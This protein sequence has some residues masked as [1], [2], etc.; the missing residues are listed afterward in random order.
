MI[1]DSWLYVIDSWPFVTKMSLFR[2]KK[3]KEDK[4]QVKKPEEVKIDEKTAITKDSEKTLRTQS[5]AKKGKKE[6]LKKVHG[7]AYKYL[8]KPIIT[9]KASSLG[10][11]NQYVFEVAPKSNKVEIK[12]AIENLYGVRPLK[13]NIINMRGKIVRYGRNF[14]RTRN[15]KKAIVTLRSGDKID[16]YQ[17]V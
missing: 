11:Y 10:V 16:V 5:K 12:K 15:W 4:D 17:G 1:R 8:I 2:R 6:D 3:K 7:H 9:E 13:V 14:G